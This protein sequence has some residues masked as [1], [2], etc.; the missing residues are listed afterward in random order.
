M[1][2]VRWFAKAAEQES[3]EAQLVLGIMHSKGEYFKNV[4]LVGVIGDI[5]EKL[6]RCCYS[7]S[8]VAGGLPEIS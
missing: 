8:I 6:L 7:H 4:V 5:D 3:S 2:A 1:K